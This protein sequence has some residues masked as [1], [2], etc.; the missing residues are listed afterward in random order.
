V[1]RRRLWLER[2]RNAVRNAPA[3][4]PDRHGQS[5]QLQARAAR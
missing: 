5:P 1:R 3:F 4:N 2:D